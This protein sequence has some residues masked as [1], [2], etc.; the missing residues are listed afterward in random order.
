M[1]NGKKMPS[2]SGV[3]LIPTDF[4][5]AGTYENGMP[6]FGFGLSNCFGG[7]W[8]M[9]DRKGSVVIIDWSDRTAHTQRWNVGGK[10]DNKWTKDEA[11]EWT[12]YEHDE[13]DADHRAVNVSIGGNAQYIFSEGEIHAFV[14]T[15]EAKNAAGGHVEIVLNP[16]SIEIRVYDAQYNCVS[17]FTVPV[18]GYPVQWLLDPG[19][20]GR[21]G[22][23]ALR[24][25]GTLG[26][27]YGDEPVHREQGRAGLGALRAVDAK[28]PA[29][30]A[31]CQDP[32]RMLRSEQEG[33]APVMVFF[34]GRML[35]GSLSTIECQKTRNGD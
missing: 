32:H 33:F 34:F 15:K 14:T 30:V 20:L 4:Y 25:R 12:K 7:A 16:G 13:S 1:S 23:D 8:A 31:V 11:V 26:R 28:A 27:F 18:E 21:A 2:Q 22:R 17:S 3:Q 9:S 6:Y 5:K 19:L 10:N 29:T 24:A 35:P